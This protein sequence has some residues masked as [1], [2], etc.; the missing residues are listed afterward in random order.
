MPHFLVMAVVRDNDVL[1][2]KSF[3]EHE[4][5]GARLYCNMLGERNIY[6]EI[7]LFFLDY[8]GDYRLMRRYI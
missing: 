1:M 3:E 6:R 5:D 4:L 8:R 7:C 2:V